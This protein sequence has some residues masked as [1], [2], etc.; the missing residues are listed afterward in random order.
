MTIEE[1]RAAI[2]RKHGIE[3]DP[4]IEYYKQFDDRDEI[5]QNLKLTVTQRFEKAIAMGQMRQELIDA[6]YEGVPLNYSEIRTLYK[7]WR[8]SNL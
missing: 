8:E 1:K 3:P 6:G 4:V 7:A 2:L 5:R